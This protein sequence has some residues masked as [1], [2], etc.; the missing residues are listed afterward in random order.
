MIGDYIGNRLIV[1]GLIDVRLAGE[2][3]SG[4]ITPYRLF[5]TDVSYNIELMS[6]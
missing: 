2:Y 1:E 6:F 5:L 3:P 4:V